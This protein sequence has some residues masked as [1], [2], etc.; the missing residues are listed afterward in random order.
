MSMADD[1]SDHYR[2]VSGIALRVPPDR[3]DDAM[4]Q[5]RRY[6]TKMMVLFRKTTSVGN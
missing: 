3:P 2:T 1:N 6:K 4:G 5:Q